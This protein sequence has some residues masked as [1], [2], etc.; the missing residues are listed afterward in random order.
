MIRSGVIINNHS[1]HYNINNIITYINYYVICNKLIT[2]AIIAVQP[3]YILFSKIMY[4]G[5][6]YRQYYCNFE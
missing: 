6:R 3:V 1:V 4:Q 2:A 5:D